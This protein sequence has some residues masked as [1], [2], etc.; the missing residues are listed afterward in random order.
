[1]V[2]RYSYERFV[3]PVPPEL[4]CD[5]ICK[6][7]GCVN[8]DHI[9]AVTHAENMRNRD[10]SKVAAVHA[11]RTHCPKGHPYN[12]ENTYYRPD[13]GTRDCL[14]CRRASSRAA[15]ARRTAAT[16]A[17][18]AGRACE[19]GAPADVAREDGRFL[20]RRCHFLKDIRPKR[21]E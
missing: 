7:R 6:N 8:P 17:K 5:H 21:Y 20:C 11:D 18:R 12:A 13:N 14:T 9:R 2:H 1:M 3:G 15:V 4:E 16:R 10:Y 19:C